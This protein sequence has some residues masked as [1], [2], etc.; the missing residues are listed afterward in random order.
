MAGH[1]SYNTQ[2]CAPEQLSGPRRLVESPRAFPGAQSTTSDRHRMPESL[3]LRTS[4]PGE[5]RPLRPIGAGMPHSRTSGCRTLTAVEWPSVG[6]PSWPSVGRIP[7]PPR[8]A[9]YLPRRQRL[10]VDDPGEVAHFCQ[11]DEP[12]RP[13]PAADSPTLKCR[14]RGLTASAPVVSRYIP[15]SAS[16]RASSSLGNRCP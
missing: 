12:A 8:L 10:C 3:D 5:P 7:W 1:T 11:S 16:S 9:S 13:H 2:Y 14:V 6:S 15:S 4:S